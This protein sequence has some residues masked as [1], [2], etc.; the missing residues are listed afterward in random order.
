M[1]W[2]DESCP[3]IEP[4]N[5]LVQKSPQL[6]ISEN[7]QVNLENPL[8]DNFV[9]TPESNPSVQQHNFT[10]SF[11]ENPDPSDT[12]PEIQ[13]KHKETNNDTEETNECE[14]VQ[15]TPEK[16]EDLQRG[17]RNKKRPSYLEDYVV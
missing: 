4:T 3:T 5:N 9:K 10:T 6:E 12:P 13:Q 15:E 17:K 16:K 2:K 8:E 7:S 11:P 1:L 14:V